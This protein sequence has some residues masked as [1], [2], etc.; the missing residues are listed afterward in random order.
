MFVRSAYNYDMEEVSRETGLSMEYVDPTTGEVVRDFG[1]TQQEFAKDADINEIVRRFG[2]TGHLPDVVNVPL[3]GDFTGIS[4]YHSAVLA[5]RKAE[6]DFMELPAE[7]RARFDNDPQKLM[8][9]LDNGENR[10][11]AIKL[12]LVSKPVA[13]PR[14]AV[15]AID[16]LAAKLVVPKATG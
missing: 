2:L 13:V 6:E 5:V 14:D 15:T 7:M 16:E 10:D 11:E 4:D 9:F 1:M 8:N 12:G 3:S